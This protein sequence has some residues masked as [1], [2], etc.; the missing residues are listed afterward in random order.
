MKCLLG[1]DSFSGKC[2]AYR[3]GQHTWLLLLRTKDCTA[4]FMSACGHACGTEGAL[5]KEQM[6]A[7]HLLAPASYQ[8]LV[9]SQPSVP[10]EKFPLILRP[11]HIAPKVSCCLSTQISQSLHSCSLQDLWCWLQQNLSNI[12]SPVMTLGFLGRLH[13]DKTPTQIPHTLERDSFC[14]FHSAGSKLLTFLQSKEIT[15]SVCITA[16]YIF[17]FFYDVYLR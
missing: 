4:R 7:E 5:P 9:A 13:L 2:T 10:L 17:F 3:S 6:L 15:I 16:V 1:A 12:S 8:K 11:R 14:H